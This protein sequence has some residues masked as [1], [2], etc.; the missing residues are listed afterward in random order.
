MSKIKIQVEQLYKYYMAGNEKVEALQDINLEIREG[1]FFCILGPSGCGKSTLINIISGFTN[2]STGKVI[3]DGQVLERPN[4]N[5]V[6]IFQ[7]YGLFP[8]RTVLDNARFGLEVKGK[9]KS[10]QEEIARRF[11]KMVRLDGFENKYPSELSGG[12]RQRLALARALAV[13]PEAIFLDEPLN[14]L[15][16]VSRLELQTELVRIW[17]EQRKTIILVT[18]DI[19]ESIFMAE[20]IGVMSQR[21]G[22]IEAIIPVN[23]TYPRDRSN[24]QFI[25]AKAV[26]L[27][28]LQD[29]F[30]KN[31]RI[32]LPVGMQLDG[33]QRP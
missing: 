30:E 24:P 15:D 26:V 2:P 22:R 4:P 18:H 8:W 1:E 10:E 14:A 9:P 21:P 31:G 3:V 27:A 33:H 20:R 5:Y 11:L 7:E 16:I 32:S 6:A 25:Q 12:M 13:D 17:R 29:I 28:A 19:E 23:L